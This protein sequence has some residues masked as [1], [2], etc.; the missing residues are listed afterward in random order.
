VRMIERWF[1]C[2]EVSE[3]SARGWGSGNTEVMLFPWFAKRPLAQAKAAVLTSLLPWPENADEQAR[4]QQLV[5]KAMTARDAEHFEVTRELARYFPSGCSLLD[6]FSGRAMIPLEAARLGTAAHGVDYSPVAAVAGR[7]LADYPLRDWSHEPVLPIQDESFTIIR[8]RLLQD[9]SVF[10]KEVERRAYKQLAPFYPIVNG[11]RPWGYLWAMTLPCQECNSRFPLIGSVTLRQPNPAKGDLGQSLVLWSDGGKW[12]CH[13]ID[14]Q[15]TSTPTR[16]VAQGK[17][18]YDSSGKIAICLHCGHAHPKDVHTRLAASG[19]GEDVLL[20]VADNDER[21]QRVFRSPVPAEVDAVCLAAESLALADPFANGLSP[22]TTE[23]IPPG[24]TWTIQPTVYGAHTF[25]DLCNPRQNLAFYHLAQAI[26]RLAACLIETGISTEYATALAEYGT[27]VLARRLKFSTRGARLRTPVGSVNVSDVF[28]NSESSWS[29][30]YDYLETGLTT[31]PGTWT[32]LAKDTVAV[33]DTQ[34]SRAPGNHA[35]ITHGSACSL[36]FPDAS[37][38]AVVT[39]PPYDA[40]IDYTDASDL[41]YVWMKRALA[42]TRPEFAFTA[43]PYGVQEKTEEIIVKKGNPEGDHRTPGHYDR[44]IARAFREAKRVVRDDGVVTIVFGHGDPDVWHRLLGAIT[45]AGLVL[46]GS[47]PARTEKAKSGGG[48]NIVTTLTMACRPAPAQR[49]S[50]R[51]NLVEAAVKREVK[52]RVPMWEAGGLA[53]TDQLMASAGPAMEVVGRYSNV[54]DHRGDPIDPSVYLVVARRAVEEA[55]TVQI[56]HLPLESFDSRTRF[57]LSW[58]RLYHRQLAPKSEARWQALAS[59]LEFDSLKGTVLADLD[60]GARLA[61]AS[62]AN[63]GIDATASTIDIA[64]AIA[65]AWPNGLEAVA[66]ALSA[67]GRHADDRY[68]WA[69]VSYLSSRLPDADPDGQAWTGLLRA[70]TGLNAVA[71]GVVAARKEAARE[72]DARA[73]QGSLFE[74]TVG[75]EDE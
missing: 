67:A 47:W 20:A 31:G 64:F 38:D 23:R 70:R 33:L 27:S 75:G 63:R 39:D 24:N 7:L 25:A 44:L 35:S 29:F 15:S 61:F 9:V 32:S 65:R 5:R 55:A 58:V 17:H 69:T 26:D 2:Q 53:P 74:R 41:Y 1:P 40:M 59:D 46:T 34:T 10:L 3:T 62:E 22:A 72:E 18:K 16:V 54:L 43:N 50:G 66:E 4:L 52:S 8:S 73:R 45:E 51:A 48:S 11:M 14:G 30:Q 60:K 13:V 21:L 36:M 28:G 42:T 49:P 71:R 56:E 68:L 6:P 19:L 12:G 57:A 37:V